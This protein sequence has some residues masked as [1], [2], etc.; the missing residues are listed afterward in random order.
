MCAPRWLP[1]A[2]LTLLCLTASPAPGQEKPKPEPPKQKP[3]PLPAAFAELLKASPEEFLKRFDQNGDGLLAKDELPPRLTDAVDRADRN[4]DGKLD[5]EEVGTLLA[6]L[7]KQ[8]GQPQP[9]DPQQVDQIVRKFLERFDAN[10]DG[11]VSKNEAMGALAAEFERL[12]ANQDGFLDR[13]ELRKFAVQFAGTTAPPGKPRP[14][15]PRVDIPDFDAFDK[16]ADGRLTGDE[17]KGAAFADR[18]TAMDA[19]K[20]GK[21]DRKEFEG[22]FRKQAAKKDGEKKEE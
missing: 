1:F 13:D 19:N 6:V 14:P 20:D 11:Q 21:V 16:D 17:V 2:A 15:E 7:R 9:P 18:F 8:L 4:N 22:Y 10:K 3:K 12:D 5:K